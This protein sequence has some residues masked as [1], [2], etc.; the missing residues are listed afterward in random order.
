MS[1]RNL[2]FSVCMAAC[3]PRF[4]IE[5]VCWENSSACVMATV[6]RFC[7]VVMKRILLFSFF[8]RSNVCTFPSLL[9]TFVRFSDWINKLIKAG[10]QCTEAATVKKQWRA[11]EINEQWWMIMDRMSCGDAWHAHLLEMRGG[12]RQPHSLPQ[13]IRVMMWWLDDVTTIAIT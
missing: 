12:H 6:L 11:R 5:L 9:C 13:C 3:L 2:C 8:V 4:L 1:I 10:A 7:L